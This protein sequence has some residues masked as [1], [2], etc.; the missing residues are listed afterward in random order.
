M[1]GRNV[2]SSTVPT[3]PIIAVGFMHSIL[4]TPGMEHPGLQHVLRPLELCHSVK[5]VLWA[6][7]SLVLRTG[8]DTLTTVFNSNARWDPGVTE[9]V[10]INWH[11]TPLP[12]VEWADAGKSLGLQRS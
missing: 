6:G 11:C 2:L 3:D 5:Q 12:I 1:A 9:K 7:L 10:S 8:L 4:K